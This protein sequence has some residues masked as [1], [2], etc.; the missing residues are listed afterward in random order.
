MPS[1][2]NPNTVGRNRT[3]AQRAKARKSTRKTLKMA[4]LPTRRYTTR[5]PHWIA[6]HERTQCGHEQEKQRKVEKQLAHAIRR[7]AEMEAKQEVEMKDANDALKT[8]KQL[9]LERDAAMEALEKMD[10]Q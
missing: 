3:I 8:K 7:K 5:R 2:K 4:K 9:K 10:I 6:P 1:V